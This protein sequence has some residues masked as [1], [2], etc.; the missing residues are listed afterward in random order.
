MNRGDARKHQRTTKLAMSQ[1]IIRGD[2]SLRGAHAGGRGSPLRLVDFNN[3]FSFHGGGVRTYHLRKLEYYARR[4]DVDYTLMI[5]SD[6]DEVE[7][8]GRARMVHLR[9]PHMPGTTAYRHKLDPVGLGRAFA[10]ARPQLVEVGGAYV[11]PLLV[12]AATRGL[13]VCR[14]G[15]WHTH[16]PEAYFGF[17]GQR[18]APWVGEALRKVGW[19]YARRTYGAFHAVLAATRCV[20]DSLVAN[21]IHRVM[22]CPLG[23]DTERFSPHRRD[24]SLRS[25]FGAEG[26]PL[27]FFPHRLLREK[28]IFELVEAIPRILREHPAVFVLAGTGP[29]EPAV[30]DLVARHPEVHYVGYIESPEE[31]ARYYATSDLVLALSPFETFGLSIVEAMAS[32]A[33]LVGPSG[34]AGQEW[35]RLA[36]CGESATY[37]DVSSLVDVTLRLLRRPDLP[38]LGLRGHRYVTTHFRWD[39]VFE[40]QL[41]LYRRILAHVGGEAPIHAWPVRWEPEEEVGPG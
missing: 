38:D 25:C 27:V 15:F 3:M 35:I 18:L 22:E 19:W 7:Q 16:Y 13:G 32:G 39:R 2:C 30:R 14:V 11:D 21:G 26:R 31:M 9:A 40:R 34:G 23:V 37:G 4:E 12:A 10:L 28:G 24:E 8:H 1:P 17:Y 6:R 5:P 33:P 41:G 20:V 36:A 29:G